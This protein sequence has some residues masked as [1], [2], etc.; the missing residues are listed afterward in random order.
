MNSA[1]RKAGV[2][3][4]LAVVV[5]AVLHQGNAEP[6]AGD[7]WRLVWG[8]EFEGTTIDTK[9]WRW[10]P[11]GSDAEG[12]AIAQ[13]REAWYSREDGYLDGKGDLVLRI[14]KEGDTYWTAWMHTANAFT[15]TYGYLEIR[16]HFGELEVA[17][18]WPAFWI[19]VRGNKAYDQNPETGVEFDIMEYPW[20]TEQLVNTIN[21]ALHT[22]GDDG[23]WK[24]RTVIPNIR[25]DWHTFGLD[26]DR[27]Y[28][29]VY[30][31]GKEV[32]RVTERVSSAAQEIYISIEAQH[33]SWAGDL[34]GTTH[35][36]PDHWLIDYCRLYKRSDGAVHAALPA[37]TAGAAQ[38]IRVIA[39]GG[40]TEIHYA[41]SAARQV[42]I[43]M[44]DMRGRNAVA[45]F[46]AFQQS[47]PHVLRLIR[48]VGGRKCLPAGSYV[49]T[50]TV[51]DTRCAIP[52][53]IDASGANRGIH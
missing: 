24:H 27:D 16:S 6:P 37:R 19:H 7:T 12:T 52:V 8:D 33:G 30:V 42:S 13:R 40:I 49:W 25:D 34:H 4:A 18:Y 32:W 35:L 47:G 29:A 9:K 23:S 5:T 41:L 20:R 44:H 36:L 46:N 14:R 22:G 50:V 51:G 31:D 10:Y 3:A 15:Y 11:F 43:T 26:W 1:F 21:S 45:P 38:D 28:Y 2:V 39:H 17:G 48:P 53:V